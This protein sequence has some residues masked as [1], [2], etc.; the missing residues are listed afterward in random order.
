MKRTSIYTIRN[1]GV[2]EDLQPKVINGEGVKI[3]VKLN[4]ISLRN[5]LG[6]TRSQGW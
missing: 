1:G 6:V 2:E 3:Q 4:Q 5:L